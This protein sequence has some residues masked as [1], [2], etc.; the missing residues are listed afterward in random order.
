MAPHL[1]DVPPTMVQIIDHNHDS[2][3]V[4]SIWCWTLA[5]NLI[6]RN[7]LPAHFKQSSTIIP[8]GALVI[9][10][11]PE[12]RR[13]SLQILPSNIGYFNLKPEMPD[14]KKKTKWHAYNPQ[15]SNQMK[16]SSNPATLGWLVFSNSLDM[17][18]SFG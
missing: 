7:R 16:T 17:Q 6:K 3:R 4:P 14:D 2:S 12:I 1:T 10:L 15:L 18:P 8:N 5:N 9:F 13:S 11:S